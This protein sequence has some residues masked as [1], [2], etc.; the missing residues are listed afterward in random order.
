M[1]KISHVV[2]LML[3]NFSAFTLWGD[4]PQVI[5]SIHDEKAKGWTNSDLNGRVYRPKPI[6]DSNFKFSKYLDNSCVKTVEA[7]KD[8]CSGFVKVFHRDLNQAKKEG[9]GKLR[10]TNIGST[11]LNQP[12]FYFKKGALPV[13]HTLSEEFTICDQYFSSIAG[14]TWSN[15]IM[16]LSGTCSDIYETPMDFEQVPFQDLAKQMQT[17]I[18]E[19]M[20]EKGVPYKVYFHDFPLSL[21]LGGNWDP[22]IL[23]NHQSME[24]FFS[25]CETGTLPAFSWLEPRY[26]GDG[27]SMH[28]PQRICNGEELIGRVYNALR[29]NP[30]V[31]DKTLFIINYDE[32]GG[33]GDSL[34]P[35]IAWEYRHHPHYAMSHNNHHH[36]AHHANGEC[37]R[38]KADSWLADVCSDFQSRDPNQVYNLPPPKHWLHTFGLAVPCLLVS[39]HVP[40][41]HVSS[42]VYD[43]T[44]VLRSLCDRFDLDAKRLG[45]RVPLA[46]SFWPLIENKVQ[47]HNS[48]LFSKMFH[49]L[50]HAEEEKQ[51]L[52]EIALPNKDTT[53]YC[54]DPGNWSDFQL[55]IFSGISYTLYS[56]QIVKEVMYA[57]EEAVKYSWQWVMNHFH[58][59]IARRI[60]KHDTRQKKKRKKQIK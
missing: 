49:S 48:H 10:G 47:N 38:N 17:T 11:D 57:P 15:R 30:K 40:R 20:E 27:N 23:K 21:L 51:H 26:G 46:T 39:P 24:E 4:F 22:R 2:V 43:H 6:F 60:K 44:S 59:V 25:A 54:G 32:G 58:R 34:T 12:M 7:L 45:P 36:H 1:D 56:L 37:I 55:K 19:L 28:P 53:S 16:A 14:P 35:P 9:K 31:W 5:G 52:Q 8:G 3:E 50:F 41:G 33:L 13:L 42:E 29:K 18:F